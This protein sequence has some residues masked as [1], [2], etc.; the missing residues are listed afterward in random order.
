M[1]KTVLFDLD[2]TLTD[3]GEGITNS[4]AYALE[5]WGITV[6]DKTELY[7]FIGPPLSESFSKYYGFSEEESIKAVQCYRKYF[8][9]KGLYENRVYDGI[10]E[11]L[12]LIK[13][14]GIKTVLATSKPEPYAVEILKHFDLYRYFDCIAGAT[15]DE[16]RNKKGDVIA[17]ALNNF[18]ITDKESTVMVGDRR[19]DIMGAREN[20]IYNIGVLYGYGDYEE[21]AAAKADIIVKSVEELTKNLL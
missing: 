20:G 6:T 8:S 18:K 12:A 11:M 10:P 2:G 7:P 9:Q 4:V 17:Y 16:S 15:M 1:Y 14:K 13:E 19:Q 21:L 5:K 3:P